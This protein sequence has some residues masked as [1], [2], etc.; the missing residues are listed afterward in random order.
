MGISIEKLTKKF[1]KKTALHEISMKL[2]S[3]VYGLLGPNGAG[4]STL[5]K[6]LVGNVKPTSG[7]VYCDG[8]NIHQMG[9]DY[10]RMLGY[11]PQQQAL[12]SNFTAREFLGYMAVLKMVPKE[13]R[14]SRIEWAAEQVNLQNDLDYRIQTFSGGMKQRTLLAA[15]LLNDSS[16]LILDEPTAGLDPRER[17]RI[18]NLISEISEDKTVLIATHVVSDIE[19]ISREVILLQDG[20]LVRKDR[21][22]SLTKDIGDYVYET[23]CGLDELK[24]LEKTFMISNILSD[25][26]Q[27]HVH[28]IAKQKPCNVEAKH[29]LASLEDVY[30]YYFEGENKH[31]FFV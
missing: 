16:L 25:G 13:K 18:R 9:Q 12:Y 19:L 29:A 14:K 4:K 7:T 11:M 24:L 28:F 10:R 1:G 21:I 30:L 15:A 8:V 23:T 22:S 17:I 31:D 2:E 6:I 27:A 20:K 3:G 26:T 5:M